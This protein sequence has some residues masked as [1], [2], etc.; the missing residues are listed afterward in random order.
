MS[1]I[2][3]FLQG[4]FMRHT[5]IA[6][7]VVE[8]LESRRLLSAGTP[9]PWDPVVPPAAV[10]I[11]KTGTLVVKCYDG[12]DA[13]VVTAAGKKVT[14]TLDGRVVGSY[15]GVKRVL[16]EAGGGNDRVDVVGLQTLGRACT[17]MGGGGDDVLVG[18]RGVQLIGGSGNDKLVAEQ[19]VTSAPLPSL[20]SGGSGNDTLVA[21]GAPDSLIGGAG[22]DAI[23]ATVRPPSSGSGRSSTS[24]S[25]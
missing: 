4:V 18:G 22:D 11:T 6:A 5:S 13:L 25:S 14:L 2:R 9:V 17:V 23:V 24:D 3:D 16:V 7:P 12:D 15:G 21:C 8:S 1:G 10:T 19:A 20:L